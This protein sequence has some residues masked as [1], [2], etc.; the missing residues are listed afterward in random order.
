MSFLGASGRSLGGSA[1]GLHSGFLQVKWEYPVWLG[2]LLPS[3][4]SS[5]PFGGFLEPEENKKPSSFTFPVV[6]NGLPPPQDSWTQPQLAFR[7]PVKNRLRS[8]ND[9]SCLSAETQ[10]G[11]PG[12]VFM[13]AL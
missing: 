1:Q 6:G 10:M 13:F 4:R 5:E 8:W 2:G 3:C 7:R 12:W 11:S 9:G